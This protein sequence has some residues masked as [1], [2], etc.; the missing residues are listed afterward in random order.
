MAGTTSVLS[1]KSFSVLDR[2][3]IKRVGTVWLI[4]N[5][6]GIVI[7]HVGLD[8]IRLFKALQSELCKEATLLLKRLNFWEG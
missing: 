2:S 1:V 6:L 7:I 5:F 4:G 8:G 3:G